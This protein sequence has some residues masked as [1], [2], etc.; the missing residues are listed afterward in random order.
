[1]TMLSAAFASARVGKD[2]TNGFTKHTNYQYALLGSDALSASSSDP[3][4]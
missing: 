4:R 3:Q 2:G 1:M